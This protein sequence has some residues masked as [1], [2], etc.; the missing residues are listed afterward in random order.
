[1]YRIVVADSQS[2]RDGRF[3]EIVGTYA[4]RQ[5]EGA[6]KLD[7]SRIEYWMDHGAQP[8]DT[9]RSIM[10]KAGMLKRRHEARLATKL[11]ARAVPLPDGAGA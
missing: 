1:M 4:P 11:Q 8:T 3:I 9:V 7:E 6:V 2:P 10:R 5:A